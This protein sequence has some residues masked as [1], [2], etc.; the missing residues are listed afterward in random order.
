MVL[1]N[2]KFLTVNNHQ[3]A[4]G[5]GRFLEQIIYDVDKIHFLF[6]GGMK[7]ILRCLIK[8][9]RPCSFWIVLFF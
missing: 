1:Q 4:F 2:F 8:I 6:Y 9:I 5:G 3:D 7:I